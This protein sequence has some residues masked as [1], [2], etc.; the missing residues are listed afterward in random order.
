MKEGNQEIVCTADMKYNIPSFLYSWSDK[1][2][3]ENK[4]VCKSHF[5]RSGWNLFWVFQSIFLRMI[6]STLKKEYCSV[7]TK[8]LNNIKWRK[9]DF[10]SQ[11]LRNNWQ[12]D[13]SRILILSVK[14]GFCKPTVYRTGTAS[15]GPNISTY[16]ISTHV[17]NLYC[18]VAHNLPV[19]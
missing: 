3:F 16:P 8:K 19:R 7:R 2:N 10:F 6:F 1:P 4:C 13:T 5:G 9:R 18:K 11:I 14:E 17:S 15:L 12:W